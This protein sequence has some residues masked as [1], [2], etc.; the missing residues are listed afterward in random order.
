MERKACSGARPQES[1]RMLPSP[2]FLSPVSHLQTPAWH[3]LTSLFTLPA[4]LGISN[5]IDLAASLNYPQIP[6]EP[7][8]KRRKLSRKAG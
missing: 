2:L 5:T 6:L 1:G 8:G 3:N 4:S 7:G